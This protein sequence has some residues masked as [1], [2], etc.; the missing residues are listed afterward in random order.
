MM[1]NY[2]WI[3][4]LPLLWIALGAWLHF[5][6]PNMEHLVREKGQIS[7]P[8]GFP[9]KIKA[10]MLEEHGGATGEAVLVVYHDEAG[11]NESQLKKIE[12][13]IAQIGTH[14]GSAKVEQVITPFDSEEQREMLISEDGSTML[15]VLMVK[16]GVTEVTYVRPEIEKAIQVEGLSSYLTGSAIIAEDVIISS[17]EGL[18][19]TEIITVVFVLAILFF[20]FRS[21]AAPL[22]PLITVGASYIVSVSIV[23]Y[24]I[25][26]LN[27]PV[28]NFTQI[29]IVAVLF[30]IGTD[31]CILLLTRFKEE[32]ILGKN[33]VQAMVDTYKA[34]GATVF[35]SALT[36]FIGFF[37][38]GF[39]DFDLYRSA[40]SVA[41]GIVVLIVG[42]WVWVPTAML[43]LGEKL[44]WPN[45]G[46]LTSNKSW[47]WDKLGR[48]SVYKPGW[49]LIVLALLLVPALL[50]YRGATS[51][52]TLNEIGNEYDSVYAFELIS[53]NF[54]EGQAFPVN[55]VLENDEQWSQQQWMPYIEL[56]TLELAKIDG[57]KEVRSAT[58]PKG[59]K[60][61]EFT[62]P[63]I[64]GEVD[65]GL[66][67]IVDGLTEVRET[68]LEIASGLTDS[69]V[70][71]RGAQDDVVQL[72]DGTEELQ[73][74]AEQLQEEMGKVS[75]GTRQ[76]AAGL[77]QL[78]ESVVAISE[79]MRHLTAGGMLP[80]EMAG[81]INSLADGLGQVSGG[82]SEIQGGL[83]D[84]SS[85]QEQ[86][87]SATGDVASGIGE[88]R[89]GQG[90]IGGAF[91]EIEDAFGELA[92]GMV[93]IADGIEE[94]EEGLGEVR[95]L[96]QEIA[97]QRVNP[98]SG[99]F[100]PKAVLQDGELDTLWETFTTPDRKIAKFDVILD[101]YPYSNDAIVIVNDIED[102]MHIA[103]KGT[104]FEDSRFSIGGLASV[105]RDLKTISDEDFNRTA[106]IMLSGIF[107][108]LVFLLRSLVMPLYIM[109]SLIITYIASMTFTEIIFIDILGHAGISWAVPF[110]G[111]VM[112]MALGVDYSIF[113]MGRFGE[114]VRDLPLKE[115]MV[116]A[117]GQI[118]TVILSAA[119]ILAGTFGA[120]MP[121]GVMSLL[122]I[123]TLVLTGLL[124]YAFVMLPLFIP[125]MVQLF[126][127]KNWWPFR[128]KI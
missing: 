93:E 58:R 19:K 28:S 127:N 77:A 38:I 106:L 12:S 7:V 78:N 18:A 74:G 49:T 99:F 121:S 91:G 34:E 105:N 55:V 42:L 111:F 59:E 21:L 113:L 30:G 45:R 53:E 124:L 67:E 50:M 70:D 118:G 13:K 61:E 69:E 26:H 15:V 65:D 86:I 117:M 102:R 56:V 48:F 66:E 47:L 104:P 27:F 5:N 4:I 41:V 120:M 8:E 23:G 96:F 116:K 123:A 32:L 92:E 44:F 1:R 81:A 82:I 83:T 88:V 3:F 62:I 85:G 112:L 60:V 36:G 24:M 90:E 68:L 10:E 75:E 87:A 108:V 79:Q 14:L 114:L 25:E 6:A 39:A 2:R 97:S 126:G 94:I 80:P 98:L 33:R 125:V 63:Y 16:M 17:E 11:L 100:I 107:I 95:E 46:K 51:M 54:S 103:L 22:V 43:L 52:D 122:Q 73:D 128:S 110:F 57:V 71:M 35:Y 64:V 119:I 84:L 40:V 31:Y 29:F 37:A 101:V 109:A 20:V 9:S 76:S 72:V 115:A 89:K